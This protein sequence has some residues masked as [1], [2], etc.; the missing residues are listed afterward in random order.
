MKRLQEAKV[1][2]IDRDPLVRIP[3]N[4]RFRNK[5][6]ALLAVDSTEKALAGLMRESWDVVLCDEHLPGIGG[7]E[8]LRVIAG[9]WP[10]VVPLMLTGRLGPDQLVRALAAGIW[11][12]VAK[13]IRVDLLVRA[14]SAAL[15]GAAE[16]SSGAPGFFAGISPERLLEYGERV[17]GLLPGFGA[18]RP[19]TEPAAGS[20]LF[21]LPKAADTAALFAAVNR[22]RDLNLRWIL[23]GGA[24]STSRPEPV[25]L[26]PVM[27]KTARFYAALCRSAGIRFGFFFAKDAADAVAP[28]SKGV[29]GHILDNFF[30]NAVHSLLARESGGGRLDLS[31]QRTGFGARIRIRDNGAG[32]NPATAARARCIGF[33]TRA[34]GTGLGLF[35]ADRL[36]RQI[37]AKIG[38]QSTPGQGC[39]MCLDLFAPSG[40]LSDVGDRRLA[41]THANGLFCPDVKPH[42]P[43]QDD[44]GHSG[45]HR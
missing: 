23:L 36:S 1:L 10:H 15:A 27:K 41:K 6:K 30:I 12:F 8:T 44:S 14:L 17:E 32:M 16:K 25:R 7:V 24:A 5:L 45:P 11:G 40:L 20:G 21:C 4:L 33:S 28:A 18:P 34:N 42:L 29:L 19:P 35:V 37:G 2:I 3:F 13:P 9:R 43:F 39:A 31:V 22:I 26:Y 38:I